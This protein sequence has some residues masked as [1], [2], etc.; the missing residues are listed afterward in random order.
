MENIYNP[1]QANCNILLSCQL[2]LVHLGQSS[3]LRFFK[4]QLREKKP[5]PLCPWISEDVSLAA[6]VGMPPTVWRQWLGR[7]ETAAD[8]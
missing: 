1:S 7:R 8:R 6:A 3:S 2:L 4:L 5:F